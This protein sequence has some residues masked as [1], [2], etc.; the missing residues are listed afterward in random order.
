MG[1]PKRQQHVSARIRTPQILTAGRRPILSLGGHISI[2]ENAGGVWG[3]IDGERC[4]RVT[5]LRN[6]RR[7]KVP[8]TAK[9][10]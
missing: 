8:Y 5:R 3:R 7:K 6:G 1:A 2:L 9:E 4:D 10:P